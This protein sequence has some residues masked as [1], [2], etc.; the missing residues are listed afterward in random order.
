MKKMIFT[1][2]AVLVLCTTP[3]SAHPP[4]G[5]FVDGA[6]IS[7]DQA[8]IIIE[9][10]TLVPMRG[11]F[12]ALGSEVLWDEPAQTITSTK[13]DDTI[14]LK[15]GDTGVYKNGELVYT[16]DVP[17]RI[18]NERT[19]VPV[20]AISEAFGTEITWD[21][22]GYVIGI[23]SVENQDYSTSVEAE[24]GTTVL[25]FEMDIP[26]SNGAYADKI[27]ENFAEQEKILSTEFV[28]DFGDEAKK[29]YEKAKATGDVFKPY[30][31]TVSYK[32]T[33]DDSQFASF[34]GTSTKFTGGE[35]VKESMSYTYLAG[36]GKEVDL[37]DVVEDSQEEVEE[38]LTTSFEAL[39]DE[40]P[41]SF[42]SDAKERLETALDDVGFY[43]TK[44]GIGF[45]L[46]SETIAPKEAGV[47]SFTL[48]Y[49][50]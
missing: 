37:F 49:D 50:M 13:G 46:P 22:V 35:E 16:M 10:R 14:V 44:D 26:K 47:I 33:R 24:D 34:Y 15:I 12:Q 17:A 4:I 5:V 48:K 20:R 3:A 43:L 32:M 31:Y 2:V 41:K 21:P 11:I 18:I 19:L 38:F 1:A 36:S 8:P 45:Y 23:T 6:A 29:E 25:S 39:I 9:D 42:Y 28:E 40:Q 7:F 30:T 27:Q